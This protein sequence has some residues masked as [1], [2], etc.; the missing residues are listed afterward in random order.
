ME[1]AETCR[2]RSGRF[3]HLRS[4]FAWF[5]CIA[6][7]A[8]CY[9][10]LV[11]KPAVPRKVYHRVECGQT[12]WSIARTYGVDLHT[13]ARVNKLFNTDVLQIG[14]NLYIP[15]AS[16]WLQVV[17]RCPCGPSTSP[18]EPKRSA[19]VPASR[20]DQP[21]SAASRKAAVQHAS[22]IWP[23]RGTITRDFIQE[24]QRR[25][26]GIDIAAPKGTPIRAAEKGQVIYSD[27]GPGGYG[28]IVIVR[29]RANLVTIYAHNH[30]NLVR[31]GQFVRQGDHLATVG[32]SGRASGYHL[33]FEM[34]RKT[35]PVSPFKYLSR[36]Q[37]VARL[38]YC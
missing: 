22:F 11:P 36:T 25:H 33:H 15:G 5:V 32:K 24:G 3:S 27:W 31:V 8:G 10:G 13:L 6:L 21:A 34:R 7:C 38:K 35:V 1:S 2:G 37:Q 28:R 17:S 19:R 20:P 12:L 30:R 26:D 16:Q 9:G 14:Q 23:I 29:H 4:G 18:R